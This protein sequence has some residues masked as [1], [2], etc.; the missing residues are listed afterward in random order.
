MVI[1]V[2]KVDAARRGDKDSF[3]QVYESIAPDLYK[4]A[5]YTLGNAHD[6][7]DVVSETFMEAYRGIAKLRE[8][9]SFRAWIMKIL[10][11]R[12]KH[13]I[14][15]YIKSKNSFDIEAFSLSL[16][17]DG[18][19]SADV[20]EQLNVMKAMSRLSEQERLILVLSVINGYTTKEISRITGSPQGT[21][22]SKLH[23]SLAKLRKMI[24][25]QET[26]W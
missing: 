12:C 20:A 2:E 19:V 9:S 18:D 3:A 26:D 21:I 5:L 10:S 6:A 4:V 22:S 8:P 13:K 1:D 14:S 25:L 24:E 23:R 16:P 7:E 17:A 11:T 15:E